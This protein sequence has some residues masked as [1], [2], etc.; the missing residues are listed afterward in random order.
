MCFFRRGFLGFLGED[1]GAK[2]L[3]ERAV[4]TYPWIYPPGCNRHHQGLPSKTK[5]TIERQPFEDV[6]PIDN[7]DFPLSC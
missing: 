4:Q 5:M 2:V 3:Q 6:S 1:F 7:G